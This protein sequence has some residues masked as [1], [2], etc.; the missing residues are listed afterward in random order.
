MMTHMNIAFTDECWQHVAQEWEK[1]WNGAQIRPMVNITLTDPDTP[2]VPEYRDFFPQYPLSMSAPEIIE[3]ESRQLARIR[4]VGDAFPQRLMAFGP[5]SLSLYMGALAEIT[6]DSVWFRHTARS[7]AAI[8]TEMD[9]DSVWFRRVHAILDRSLEVWG[10]AVQVV[11]SD[12]NCGLDVLGAL[13]GNEQLLLDFIEG[14]TV[15]P[16]CG[17]TGCQ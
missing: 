17:A 11:H 6:D 13:R 8:S 1:F 10:D 14:N 5:G 12:V 7:L 16:R 4:W 9:T 15:G 2:K 3:I